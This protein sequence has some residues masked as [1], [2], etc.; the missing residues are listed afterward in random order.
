[1]FPP[2]VGLLGAHLDEV[3]IGGILVLICLLLIR[4]GVKSMAIDRRARMMAP[5][6]FLITFA[7]AL[8]IFIKVTMILR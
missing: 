5:S 2:P 1:V 3:L 6:I 4:E 8:L 7:V